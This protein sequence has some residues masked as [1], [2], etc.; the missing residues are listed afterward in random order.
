MSQ[1]PIY[2][3]RIQLDPTQKV[4]DYDRVSETIKGDLE[5][6]ALRGNIQ[7]TPV[8]KLFFSRDNIAAIQLGLRNMVLTKTCGK[9]RIG[10]QSVDELLTIMRNIF[11]QNA[12]NLPFA[13]VKQVQELN[14]LVLAFAVPR[15][16][17][18]IEQYNT[19][20]ND[21]QK[22][23]QFFDRPKDTSIYGT[24]TVEIKRF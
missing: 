21:I 17:N 19:Y 10:E 9:H 22:G 18:E 12:K 8:S 20:L 2:S 4:R 1:T 11:Y 16:I 23:P 14:G 6:Q 5:A 7:S 24:K 13:V 3:G 15:I